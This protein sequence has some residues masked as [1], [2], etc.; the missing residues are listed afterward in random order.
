MEKK[1]KVGDQSLLGA[2]GI[3]E[4]NNTTLATE[5]EYVPKYFPGLLGWSSSNAV[6]LHKKHSPIDN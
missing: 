4:T 1:Q 2:S 3:Q 5:I 6:F